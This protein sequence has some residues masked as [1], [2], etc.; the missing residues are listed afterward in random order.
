MNSGFRK[1][2]G[3]DR[4]QA[5]RLV[6]QR[7]LEELTAR[8]MK[9][10]VAEFDQWVASWIQQRWGH[11]KTRTLT[12]YQGY[13]MRWR[14]YLAKIG[15]SS[16]AAVTREHML[17][18]TDY[19]LKQGAGRNTSIYELKFFAQVLDEAVRRDYARTNVARKL[20]LQQT[21]H[22]HKVPWTDEELQK[23]G[24]ALSQAGQ[25][26][27]MHVTFLMGFYQASRL[28][29]CAV[30]LRLVDL[31]RK[32]INYSDEGVKGGKGFS[33]PIDP[34]FLP[35]LRAIKEK[36]MS[37]GA[38]TLCTLPR[39][40]SIEWRRFLDTLNLPHLSHHGLRATWITRAAI[41]G[42]PEVQTRRFVNHASS[43]VH[44]IYQRITATDIAPIFGMIRQPVLSDSADISV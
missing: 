16:P 20:G 32:L 21:A 43:Q 33:Q 38:D 5:K 35:M 2:D 26:G 41:A 10:G 6:A 22:E 1:D 44:Q 37:E 30:A 40:P 7:S 15:V 14:Q 34:D 18:Y 27:W 28:R 8:P 39:M 29:Q 17:N 24:A 12:Q 36:R 13:F 4:R 42:V 3:N 31:N 11:K 23:V 9:A 19:R 25:F